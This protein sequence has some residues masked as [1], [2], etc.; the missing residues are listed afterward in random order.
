MTVIRKD[1]QQECNFSFEII[2]ENKIK[3]KLDELFT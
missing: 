3:I 1:T 2:S